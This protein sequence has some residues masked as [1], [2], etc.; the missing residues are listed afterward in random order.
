[1]L[2]TEKCPFSCVFIIFLIFVASFRQCWWRVSENRN[3]NDFCKLFYEEETQCLKS[4]GIQI[5]SCHFPLRQDTLKYCARLDDCLGFCGQSYGDH[6]FFHKYMTLIQSYWAPGDGKNIVSLYDDIINLFWEHK[7]GNDDK[8][9]NVLVSLCSTVS[10]V[11]FFSGLFWDSDVWVSTHFD[12][13]SNLKKVDWLCN[14]PHISLQPGWSS[15]LF[16]WIAFQE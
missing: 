14:W 4:L 15:S 10:V 16:G 9:I 5:W 6:S 3:S 2:S 13:W 1:M 12:H 7:N 8:Y 11:Y